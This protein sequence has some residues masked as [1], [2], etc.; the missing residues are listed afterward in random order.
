[1]STSANRA[2]SRRVPPRSKV[3][4]ADTW[5]LSRLFT[6]DKAWERA[7]IRWSKSFARYEQYR[8]KLGKS[9]QT[10]AD[11]IKLDLQVSRQGERL[12]VY[13]SLRSSEDKGND[14]YQAMLAKLASTG[15]LAAQA[16]SFIQP[17]LLAIPVTKMRK[18]L[19]EKVLEEYRRLLDQMLRHRPHTLGPDE[20]RLLA[21]QSEMAGTASHTFTQL[22]NADLRFGT[23]EDAHGQ[24][25]ELSHASFASLMQ[26][27][28]RSVRKAAFKQYYQEY[29]HHAQTIAATLRGSILTDVYYAKARNHPSAL[30]AALFPDNVPVDVYENLVW[31][32][33]KCLPTLHR[34]YEVRRRA[35]KLKAIHHYDTYVPIVGK[36]HKHHT[37]DQAVSVIMEA[38]TPLGDKYASVLENGLRGRWCDRYENKG[39]QSG[40]FSS[41]S[42]DSDPYILMNYQEDVLDHVF[43]LAHEAGHSMHSYYSVKKQAYQDYHYRIFVAEVASTF[44]EQLLSHYLLENAETDQ[45]RAYYINR[46]IDAIR[47]TMFRQTMFAEFE[48]KTHTFAESLK[49]LTLDVF[50]NLYHSL[51]E[52]Y[53]GKEFRIDECLSLE[54]LRIPHFYHAFYVYKYATGMA[55]AIALSEGVLQG[56]A[57]ERD[58]YLGFLSSGCSKDPLDLLRDAGVD[59]SSPQPIEAALRRF[60]QLVDQL[61][62]LL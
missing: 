20:E 11:C 9:A 13:A 31:T 25:I 28:K 52:T 45:E 2:K 55:A 42:F 8:G 14:T 35:M 19:K 59:M 53:F 7:F 37:W 51:L 43:T 56:G 16:S 29:E 27:R 26:S 15:S 5:D 21:M 6:D 30:H 34:Y 54:C 36:I 4:E 38:I 62:E 49:P 44:N 10:I 18:F 61:D 32:T 40:A 60:E 22:N 23:I 41:G 50:R 47:A 58:A 1:M 33:R 17:E 48:R 12:G 39:K 24:T 57:K 46:E 3:K